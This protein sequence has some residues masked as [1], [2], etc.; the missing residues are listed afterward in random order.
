MT[1]DHGTLEGYETTL[2]PGAS[3]TVEYNYTITEADDAAGSV[4]NTV[5]GEGT[6]TNG[7][8][9]DDTDSI[10]TIVGHNEVGPTPD[11]KDDEEEMSA[12]GKSVTVMYDSYEHTVSAE[13]TKPGSTILYSTDGGEN[14]TEEA[15][16]RIEVGETE[17]AI[18]AT[19]PDYED[20]IATGFKLVVTKRPITLTSASAEK[21]YDG[22]P[23]VRNEQS[24]VTIG[25]EGLA[26]NDKLTFNITGS[27]TYVGSSDNEF[28]YEFSKNPNPVTKLFNAVKN[29]FS[30]FAADGDSA[31]IAENY[32]ITV[33]YG[34]L[35]VTDNGV[36]PDDVVVKTH[37]DKEYKVGDTVT[38]TVKATNIYDEVKTITLKELK[39][40]KLEQSVFEDV[41]PGETV[42]TTATYTITKEDGK[43][44]EFKNV[45]KAS[46]SGEDKTFENEDVV[47]DIPGE[48]GHPKT[49]D[50]GYGFD[51]TMLFGSAAALVAMLAG[52]RRREQ[53]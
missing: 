34:T 17:F 39:G 11:P 29:Y 38:F 9:V 16:T 32:D 2:A 5:K 15:P 27:Q 21:V 25:G 22:T 37:K 14:W 4:T 12:D 46:F 24:D 53:E 41:Q 49:G 23:L 40:V 8:T 44:G 42:E 48:S 3:M 31:D 30:A 35:T 7:E 36:D 33:S 26:D 13:A 10:T 20:V 28:T 51:L 43:N 6:G 47:E 18:K 45:V 1:D 52:R 19:N 50:N